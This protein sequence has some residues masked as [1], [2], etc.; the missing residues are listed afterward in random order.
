M[1]TIAILRVIGTGITSY[2]EFLESFISDNN[3][4]AKETNKAKKLFELKD[5][6]NMTRDEN[7]D[8]C[9][10]VEFKSGLD[11]MIQGGTLE[12]NLKLTKNI[13][14][15][16]MYIFSE[17]L[18]LT[19]YTNANDILLDFYDLRLE[20]YESRKKY[21][22]ELLTHTLLVLNSKVRFI[23][24][25]INGTIDINRKSKDYIIN[26]LI[27]RGYPKL[28]S[29]FKSTDPVS[30][31]YLIKMQLISLSLER[32]TELENQRNSKEQ[33]LKI[34]KSKSEKQLWKDD[35]QQLLKATF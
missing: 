32:I 16:N 25:Y 23:N 19:K 18:I 8:I 29:T 20:F 34:L 22:V 9:I 35:L 2:K 12:K 7:S 30:F 4:K 15:N 14:T 10:I 1:L 28:N 26:L 21:L 31:D 5:V 27:E 11:E 13:S 3:T 17:N 6:K 33:E 24:E